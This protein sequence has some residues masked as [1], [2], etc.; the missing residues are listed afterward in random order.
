MGGASLALFLPLQP[1]PLPPPPEPVPENHHYQVWGGAPWSQGGEGSGRRWEGPFLTPTQGLQL[2]GII[3]AGLRAPGQVLPPWGCGFLLRQRDLTGG[4]EAQRGEAPC[5][6]SHSRSRPGPSCLS[7]GL[8]LPLNVPG[9][10]SPNLWVCLSIPSLSS[11]L[12]LSFSP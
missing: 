2:P 4:N 9:S 8:C 7:Q 10:L 12:L 5:P 11:S 3:P 1:P 6:G